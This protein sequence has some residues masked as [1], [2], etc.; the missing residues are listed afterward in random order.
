MT[1]LWILVRDSAANWV[2]HK[3]ARAGA[4]L[5]Y[6]S[7]FSLGPLMVI[8]VAIAGL[9][10]GE[11]AARGEVEMQL[12][13]LFGD[14]G[15]KAIDA[16]LA[17]ASKPRQGILATLIGTVILLVTA[18]GVVV[19]LKDAFN[20]VWEIDPKK[21]SGVRQFIRSYL[22]SLAAV[23]SLGFLLL[24]SLLFTAALS[25]AGKYFGGQL[26]EA[27]IQTVGSLISFAVV[28]A[29]FAMMFKW[30]PDTP[31]RWRDVWLG[32]AVTAFL[33]ETGKLLIGIYIGKESFD[34]TYG[35]AA[36]LVV[37]L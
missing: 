34:S 4:A 31:V 17:G 25:A 33:F 19:Q 2:D 35:A 32:A 22:V 6:Y 24:V 16:M 18:M 20:T 12:S 21:I 5:A 15:A 14:A 37:L 27:P 1:K 29:M 7:V 23:I 3:D 11:Q 13:G 10:F 8:A 26:P 9:V 36:S 30:L 28:T